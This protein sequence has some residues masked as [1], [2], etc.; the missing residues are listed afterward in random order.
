MA[1]GH[2]VSGPVSIFGLQLN[3]WGIRIAK[4]AKHFRAIK[5]EFILITVIKILN[6]IKSTVIKY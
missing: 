2:L 1:S 6:P 3:L 5:I 4:Q